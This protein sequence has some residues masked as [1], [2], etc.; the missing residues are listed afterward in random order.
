[1][2]I[3]LVLLFGSIMLLLLAPTVIRLSRSG[4][5]SG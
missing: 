5:F 2:M 4:F 3:P 1:L